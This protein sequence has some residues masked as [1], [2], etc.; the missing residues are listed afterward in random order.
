MVGRE[1]QEL[2]LKA[3]SVVV[4]SATEC[5][6]EAAAR[7]LAVVCWMRWA[8]DL[9]DAC[10]LL[11]YFDTHFSPYDSDHE[12]CG[13]FAVVLGFS[14]CIRHDVFFV[15]SL[16]FFCRCWGSVGGPQRI[17]LFRAR[18]A[19]MVIA[20]LMIPSSCDRCFRRGLAV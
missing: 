17:S 1:S 8:M 14:S 19:T 7:C 13:F 11:H 2:N 18:K 4:D 16:V 9:C 20:S 5:W 10:E 3:S 6:L 12:V 15:V